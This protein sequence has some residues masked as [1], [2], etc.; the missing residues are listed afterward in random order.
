MRRNSLV[1]L[2]VLTATSARAQSTAA[3]AAAV[4]VAPDGRLVATMRAGAALKTGATKG[5]WAAVTIEGFLHKSV[6]SAKKDVLTIHAASGA[7][8]RASADPSGAVIAVVEDGV[9]VDKLSSTGDWMRVK[10]DAWVLKR[11]IKT[12]VAKAPPLV[13]GA[14]LRAPASQAAPQ[15]VAAIPPRAAPSPAPATAQTPRTETPAVAADFAASHPIVLRAAPDGAPAGS[16][17]SA[18]RV[19]IIARDHGWARVELEGWVRESELIPV[20][21]SSV[22][23]VSAAD[24]RSDPDHY[25]G[26]TVRW[27]VQAIAVQ[28]A[29]P[30]RKGLAP[31]EPYLLAR[32]PGSESSLLYLALPAPLVASARALQPLSNIM[33]LARVRAGR[34]DPSGVPILDVLRIVP[35]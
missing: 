5:D 17:D 34:S 23:A 29:D 24:L 3:T 22:S 4:R 12:V 18:A 32:G 6:I 7:A 35:R 9:T 30:L 20:D 26:S 8:L 15:K 31:D 1:I 11:E 14:P 28:Q 21:S 33:V 19:R 13:G 10:R 16:A 27:V 2:C 25:K